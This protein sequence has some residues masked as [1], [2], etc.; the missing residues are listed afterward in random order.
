MVIIRKTS[1][2]LTITLWIEQQQSPKSL[3]VEILLLLTP[4]CDVTALGPI[5]RETCTRHSIGHFGD[6]TCDIANVLEGEREVKRKSYGQNCWLLRGWPWSRRQETK[7]VHTRHHK[8][9]AIN[10][11]NNVPTR[12][13]EFVGFNVPHQHIIG[14]FGDESFQSITCTGTDNLKRTTQRQSIQIT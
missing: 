14:H 13:V 2:W 3:N 10:G 4:T 8:Q 6:G 9:R 11:T 12:W 1:D 5:K 7:G